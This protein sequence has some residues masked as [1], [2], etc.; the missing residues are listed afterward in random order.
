MHV[1]ST[2]L[3][4][5]VRRLSTFFIW[6]VIWVEKV[7]FCTLLHKSVEDITEWSLQCDSGV[8]CWTG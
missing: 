1:T 5:S 3:R 2:S 7:H 8:V 4:T 6:F